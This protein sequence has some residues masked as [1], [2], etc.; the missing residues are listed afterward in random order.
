MKVKVDMEDKPRDQESESE[1]DEMRF[2]KPDIQVV[3][4]FL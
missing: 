3:H 1:N 2:I 4:A